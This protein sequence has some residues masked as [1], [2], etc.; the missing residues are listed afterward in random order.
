MNNLDDQEFL[1]GNRIGHCPSDPKTFIPPQYHK[2][3]P[4]IVEIIKSFSE[5]YFQAKLHKS[6]Y[7]HFDQ[8][9]NATRQIRSEF[10]EMISIGCSILTHYYDVM[11]GEIGFRNDAGQSIR[12]SY[13]QL[14]KKLNVSLIRV[15]RFFAFLKEREF[16]TIIEDK[17]KD[18]NGIWKSNVSKKIIN[19]RF[20][21]ETLGISAWKKICNYKDW[22]IKKARPK[23]SKQ[24]NN[25]SMVKNILSIGR[26]GKMKKSFVENKQDSE[27]ERN[28]VKIA[29]EMYER[30]PSRNLSDYLKEL[31]TNAS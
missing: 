7:Y 5:S 14:A 10:R 29:M 31:K 26:R 27:K 21:I 2:R 1:A 18:K 4:S 11:T 8:C 12:F 19:P 20:F 6:L 28:L 30:D 25:F 9:G 3:A 15:K 17:K 13:Q 22:Q 23:T 24:H 16:V